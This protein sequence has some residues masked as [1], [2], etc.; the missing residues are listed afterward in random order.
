M[1]YEESGDT[2]NFI[3]AIRTYMEQHVDE[4]L[5]DIKYL[6]ECDSPSLYKELTD[7]CGERIQGLLVKYL[8]NRAQTLE[9]EE[10]GNHLKFEYGKGKGKILVLSHFDTV[11][12]RGDLAWKVE[13][14]LC[15][16]P[17]VLDMKGGLV[18]A[19][20]AVK[21]I[22]DLQLPLRKKI[23]FLFTSDEEIGSP[24][25]R[26]IIEEEA[27]TSY[28]A[29]VTEPPVIGTGALK[30]ARKG[31]S[32]YTIK[33]TGMAAHAGNN[34]HK[35]VNAIWEAAKIID[36]LQ[37]LTDYKKGTTVN[38]GL[39]H[40]GGKLNVIPDKAEIGVDVR[41]ENLAEQERM[42]KI[43]TSL[44]PF[45]KGS[46]IAI[47]GGINRPPMVRNEES[48]KLF[49]RA[50]KIGKSLGLDIKEASVGGVSDG[51]F[52]ASFG[53]PTLDGLGVVGEGIHAKNEH[54]IISQLPIRAA[55]FCKLLL[56]I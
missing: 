1:G 2:L 17:G 43:I 5:L 27:K 20:W 40:G 56:S 3:D 30:T 32:R 22:R 54:I 45:L 31:A 51:N 26:E 39:I 44:K 24:S 8:G 6:V 53:I 28:V 19:I 49:K 42:D 15:F 4:I 10:Y 9:Q 50:R 23:V 41:A 35:G 48:V 34:P 21:A 16:G 33:I 14:D 11:W 52:T 12:E 37:S 25:S 18:Q 55:L 46:E 36:Y 47:S 7:R 38:V 29:L 13:G